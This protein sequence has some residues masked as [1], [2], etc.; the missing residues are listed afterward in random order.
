MFSERMGDNEH[1]S[2]QVSFVFYPIAEKP[3]LDF[4]TQLRDVLLSTIHIIV[5]SFFGKLGF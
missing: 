1:S 5:V 2:S 3:P 4:Q